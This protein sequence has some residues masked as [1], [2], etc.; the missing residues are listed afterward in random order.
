MTNI[1]EYKGIKIMDEINTRPH[2]NLSITE[3]DSEY[4]IF[5]E[6][7][8]K[9][10]NKE[11][12][13]M[14]EIGCWWAFWSLCF[15]KKYPNGKNILVELGKR[16][17]SVGINNF[18]LNNFSETHYWGGFY[19]NDSNTYSRVNENYYFEKMDNEYFDDS[20]LGKM[21]GPELHIIDIISL[22]KLNKIDLLHMDIQGSEMP[23]LEDLFIN[24]SSVL[25]DK[26]DNIVVATHSQEIHNNIQNILEKTGFKILKNMNFGSVGGDG[27]LI[28]TKN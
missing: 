1:I 19:L 21:T 26:I 22:E 23:L 7:L 10:N 15:R 8:E 20:L 2:A 27:M 5:S 13:T 24:Y 11:N 14:V 17:L 28:A 3:H 9:I 16:H 6:I 4:K 18:K 25:T 12:P